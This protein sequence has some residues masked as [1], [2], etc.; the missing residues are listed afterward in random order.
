MQVLIIKFDKELRA[1][2]VN[3]RELAS[4]R[5]GRLFAPGIDFSRDFLYGA[6]T[7]L[8]T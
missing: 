2:A 8:V 5:D 6:I 7:E 4:M 1:A 3:K